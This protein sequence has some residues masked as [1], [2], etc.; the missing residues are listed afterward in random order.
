[1]HPSCLSEPPGGVGQRSQPNELGR[2]VE[3]Q[4][5][6]M[7]LSELMFPEPPGLGRSSK[8]LGLGLPGLS[9][10]CLGRDHPTLS[11]HSFLSFF[12]QLLAQQASSEFLA[13]PPPPP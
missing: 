10:H 13:F 12:R 9:W 4:T 7:D 8:P 6:W 1:M 5:A 11:R 2:A 3:G